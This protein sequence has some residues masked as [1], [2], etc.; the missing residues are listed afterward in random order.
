V[1][2]EPNTKVEPIQIQLPKSITGRID[3]PG[4]SDAFQFDAVKGEQLM[5]K[6]ESRALGYPLDP[7]LE[8]VNASDKSL[9]RVDD[10]SGGRDAQI[11]YQVA[12]DG[13]L[14][15]VVSDL[16]HSGGTDFVY[17]V[18][19][20]RAKPSY[21]LS[22]ETHQALVK[23]G[24][25]TDITLAVERVHGFDQPIRVSVNGL[26]EGVTTAPVTS[27][28]GDDSASKVIVSLVAAADTS[29]T[30]VPIRLVGEVDSAASTPTRFTVSG[31][32]LGLTQ[33][34]LTVTPSAN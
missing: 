4:D 27:K 33:M 22:A 5:I 2:S 18:S 7:V 25:S 26:P 17:R 24:E 8:L 34:W 1:E 9:T 3:K 15:L 20:E 19:I 6:I 30:S 12:A 10:S 11:L 13:P 21:R 32:P 14:R 23:A 28:V 31:H 29:A 16:H